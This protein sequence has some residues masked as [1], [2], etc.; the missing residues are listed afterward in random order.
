VQGGPGSEPGQLNQ[1]SDI[2]V[3]AAGNVYVAD[4]WNHRIQKLAPDL[5]PVGGWG[6]ATTDLM[7]PGPGAHWGPRGIAIDRDGNILVADTGTHRI[8]R[9]A[10]GGAHI[11]DA[12]RRGKEAGEF[13]EPTGI[14]VG[15]DGLI[16]VAD[17]GNARI[18]KFD[19]AFKFIAAWPLEDWADR[20]PRSKPQLE[21]LPDGRLIATDPVHGRLLLISKD[22]QVTAR[23]DTV[24]DVPLFSPNGVAFDEERGFVYLTDGLAGHIRR[25]PFTDFALR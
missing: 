14:A 23:L 6:Q 7:N 5:T 4:T 11:G 15:E 1:P 10:P 19:S 9:Y 17:A 20:N 21:A 16:Y 24:V 25:F 8:R 18:Q 22:G 2:A 13:D 3:D 12:G